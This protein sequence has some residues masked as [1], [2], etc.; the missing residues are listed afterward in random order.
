M[1][2]TDTFKYFSRCCGQ[3]LMALIF[4]LVLIKA[5]AAAVVDIMIVYDTTA[6][7]W[8]ASNGGMAAFSQDSVT[9]MNQALQNSGLTDHS[10]RLVH[11]MS[12]NYTTSSNGSTSLSPDL[13][14]LQSGSGDFAQVHS[15]RNDYGADL[16]AMMVDTG[17]AYGYVGVGYTLSSWG[18]SPNSGFTVNAIRSV[19]IGHTLTHEVGHNMGAHHS[20]AQT[21]SPGPNTYLDN[22]YSAGWYFTGTNGVKYHTILAYNNDGHGNTYQPAPFFSTPQKS[23]QGTT[24]GDVVDGDN[25]RL[26]GETI[27]TIAG[28]RSSSE[29]TYTLTV[30]S[31]GTSGV[32]IT[33][34]PVGY[35]GTTNYSKSG[36]AAG[37]GITL[38]APST[39]GNAVFASWSGCSSTSGN[40]C[41]VSMTSN[42]TVTA[43]YATPT[44]TLSVNSSGASAVPISSSTSSTYTGTTNYS[45]S[46]IS[47]GTSITLTAPSTAGNA[48]FSSWSGCSSTSG[49]NCTVSMISNKTV[50]AGYTAATYTLSVN[51]SGA[52]GV[53]IGSSTSSIYAGTTNYS[54]SGISSGTSITLTAPSTAG[55]AGFSSW[56]GC[57]ST[58]GNNCTV[59]MTS[60]KTVT[61]GYTAATYTLSVNSSG[62]SAVPISSS[63]SSTYAGTTN[64]SRSG[65][66]SGTSITLMAP[67]T[68]GSAD[69]ASWSGCS[70]ASANNCTVSMTGNK[71]VTAIY[72]DGAPTL[73]EAVDNTALSWSSGG[74]AG[75]FGQTTTAYHADDAAQS[76]DI[77]D[78]RTSSMQTTVIGP[79]TLR[80]YWR[81]SSESFDY[82]HFSIDG[83]EQPGSISGSS[84]WILGSFD[85]TSGLHTLMWTY[86]KNGLL[87]SGSDCGWVD[88]VEWSGSA[89]Q[90]A[91]PWTMFLPGII[92][93]SAR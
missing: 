72:A 19:N 47:S 93:K 56:S 7:D 53:S 92:G 32:S 1:K 67:S 21:S 3:V 84:A 25:T 64:Y 8:V 81:V 16:V 58:S 43:G 40:N 68:A 11:S 27:A 13:S 60:N 48:G 22:Q 78:N 41:T 89:D 86:T 90:K 88:Q 82:L 42:K 31:S 23:Y 55:N 66:Y 71:N 65:I 87:S 80:F 4:N 28:Y 37:I 45:R 26:I 38:T 51:S 9:R 18:G 59:S 75:W 83:V 29:T 61:A 69:F 14:A 77:G 79:G 33:S 70:V 74:D 12:V 46:G 73:G 10:F 91:F 17:S 63:T 2:K 62:V 76:G 52:S 50:T 6:T 24:V 5:A 36:I 34:S 15:A 44:Y 20:K 35:G 49:N 57:S 39:S 54:K 30:N 85:I